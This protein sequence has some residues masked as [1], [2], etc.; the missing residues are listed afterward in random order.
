MIG[1]ARA[2]ASGAAYLGWKRMT[3]GAECFP[4]A[5]TKSS[6]VRLKDIAQRLKISVSTVS[7]ALGK[8][9]CNL[10]APELRKKIHEL[11]IEAHYVPHP[12][13]QQ[14]RKPNVH[15]ITV[16]L[17][18]ESGTF[19]SE[20]YGAVLSGVISASRDGG[21]ET[22]VALIDRKEADIV[23]QMQRVAMGAGGLLYMAMPLDADELA[24]LESFGRTVVVISGSLPPGLDLST[25]RVNTVGSD[26][27][28]GACVITKE[29]LRLGHRQIGLING[30][31][32][33]RTACERE[34]GFL[35]AMKEHRG[36]IDFRAMVRGEFATD[37]G[38]QGW[39][40]VKQCS[41]RPT[42]LV[43][44][45]DEIAFGVLEA[46]VREKVD[47]PGQIS[48]V[49]FD[50]SRWAVRVTPKL[51]TARQP[52]AQL[53]RAATE[54][55]VRRLQGTAETEVEHLVFPMEIVSRQSTAPPGKP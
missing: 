37:T 3:V 49:G 39:Q 43:C 35:K 36:V 29:L 51:T 15:L 52:M 18:L 30:P 7:R 8:D 48:V 33:S 17:P 2:K 4:V 6:S 14:M 5:P 40:Q 9:T 50:D 54:L 44:G 21:T 24:K 12:A 47:C 55:L 34:E 22:R 23:E 20:Y 31:A 26:N 46:L 19:L 1:S 42:A 28:T 41:P 45:N 16:L 11:A 10:V 53:G 25:I 13:A 38:M 27:V 32:T